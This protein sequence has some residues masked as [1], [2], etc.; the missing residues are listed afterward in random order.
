MIR[1]RLMVAASAFAL[2]LSGCTVG[3]DYHAP[4][5]VV[6][7]AYVGPQPA[8]AAVDPARWWTV[9]GDAELDRLVTRA[10]A[11]NPDI[12]IAASRVRQARLAEIT[13]RAR[14]L[15]TRHRRRE[16]Q[17]RG[18]LQE[19][20]VRDDRALLLDG[21]Q[22]HAGQRHG[23]EWRGWRRRHPATDHAA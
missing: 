4:E 10:L 2:G 20:R 21:R 13:A 3:P 19:R 7:P 6:P 16:C 14:G 15:P 12:A 5:T 8:G 1:H 11:D 23:R 18:F 17:P 22:R 9:F